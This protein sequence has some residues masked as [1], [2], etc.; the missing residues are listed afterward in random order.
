LT[1]M[2]LCP[3][4][5]LTIPLMDVEIGSEGFYPLWSVVALMN[6][7]LYAIIGAPYVGLRKKREGQ[8]RAKDTALGNTN[9]SGPPQKAGP[10]RQEKEEMEERLQK[11]LRERGLLARHA[12][13]LILSGQV[14]VNGRVVREL[15][16]KADARKTGL[17]RR[18]EPS[19]RRRG[20]ACTFC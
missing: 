7:V 10:I 19:N 8:R 6:A 11:I 15:G 12:E 14:K 2:V 18:G 17:R 5:F 13:L 9:K 1:F 3:P 16:T 4:S 20:D